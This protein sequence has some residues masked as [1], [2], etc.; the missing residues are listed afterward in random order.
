MVKAGHSDLTTTQLFMMLIK[1]ISYITAFCLAVCM[2]ANAVGPLPTHH[3][4]LSA[5]FRKAS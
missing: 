1:P 4:G 3:P 5:Y 2:S